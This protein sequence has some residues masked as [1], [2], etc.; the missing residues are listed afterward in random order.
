MVN[1]CEEMLPCAISITQ[2]QARLAETFMLRRLKLL[3]V[4]VTGILDYRITTESDLS[5]LICFMLTSHNFHL[6][7]YISVFP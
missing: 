4:S 7:F 3:T 2:N 1:A 5:L 6:D